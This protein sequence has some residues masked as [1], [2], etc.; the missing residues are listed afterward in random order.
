MKTRKILLGTFVLAL[1]VAVALWL[2]SEMRID[3]CLDRAAGGIKSGSGVKELRSR[4]GSISAFG[5]MWSLLQ[6]AIVQP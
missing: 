4:A 1:L 5:R 6:Y 3:S 2:Q